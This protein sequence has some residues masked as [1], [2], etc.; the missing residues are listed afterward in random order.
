MECEDYREILSENIGSPVLPLSSPGQMTN[1]NMA[2]ISPT[3]PFNIS[4]N[5]GK[6]ENIYIGVECS[7]AKIQE[8]T[9]LFK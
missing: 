6:I 8:Y 4:H 3:I 2:N 7:R 9:E 1:G 5:I